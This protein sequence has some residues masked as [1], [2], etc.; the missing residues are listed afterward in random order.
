MPDY[1]ATTYSGHVVNRCVCCPQVQIR[2]GTEAELT[3]TFTPSFNTMN[4]SLLS[5]VTRGTSSHNF[6]LPITLQGLLSRELPQALKRTFRRVVAGV[7]TKA[8]IQV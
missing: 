3:I 8:K 6:E 7:A 2:A 1:H 5:A 4:A